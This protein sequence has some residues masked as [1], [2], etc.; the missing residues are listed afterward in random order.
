MFFFL[1]QLIVSSFSVMDFGLNVMFSPSLLDDKSILPCFLLVL[2]TLGFILYV[3][4]FDTLAFTW[5]L[6]LVPLSILISLTFSTY[7]SAAWP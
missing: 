1:M 4:V 6:L 5:S 2:S 3:Q 7:N